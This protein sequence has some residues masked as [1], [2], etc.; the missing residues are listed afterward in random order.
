MSKYIAHGTS[1]K[2]G[3]TR[4]GGLVSLSIPDRSAG[5][6]EITDSDSSD[7]RFIRG[8]RDP[9][10]V[11]V[12]VRHDPDDPGQIAIDNNYNAAAGSEV[13]SWTIELPGAATASP[14]PGGVA[15]YT[16]DGYVAKPFSGSLALADDTAAELTAT[17]RVSGPVVI[18]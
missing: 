5:E 4:I 15:K 18:T 3:S 9:G 13:V 10:S 1:M 8:M 14:S 6:A 2:I 11:E 17:I 7:R 16:F 12:T